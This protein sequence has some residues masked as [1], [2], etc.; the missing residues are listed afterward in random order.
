MK[1]YLG[2]C[3]LALAVNAMAVGALQKP[4]WETL[5]L[6]T[7]ESVLV[8]PLEGRKVLLVSEIE[9][10]SSDADGAGGIAMLALDGAVIEQNFVR[11]LNA[12][13]GMAVFA[14]TLYVADITELVAIDL[15]SREVVARYPVAEAVFLNDV[16]VD[17]KGVVYVS[18]TRTGKV[19]RL[20]NGNI[21]LYREGL[22]D[23]NGLY[24][25]G[26]DLYV[27]AGTQL[28]R[29]AAEGTATLIAEGFAENI[30]GVEAIKGGGFIVSCWAGLVY[31]VDTDGTLN[32]LLDRRSEKVNTADIGY[33]H[34]T[35][36][37]Y[38]PSFH[39]NS[40]GAYPL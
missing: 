28:L 3:L 9:G 5:S 16:A 30:D 39:G 15:G 27:G 29:V 32:L 37:L 13:K 31:H 19:H 6:R 21:D 33:D 10:G 4:S 12:P 18:D 22:A 7:P 36:T 8:H 38:I 14:D 34:E 35:H 25:E 20:V 2:A 23:A 40:V 11:G 26:T 1:V 17:V 24:T